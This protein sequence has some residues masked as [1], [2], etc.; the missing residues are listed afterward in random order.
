MILFCFKYVFNTGG[1]GDCGQPI[2]E[3][4]VPDARGSI[5]GDFVDCL[6]SVSRASRSQLDETEFSKVMTTTKQTVFIQLGI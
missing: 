3:V 4:R 1:K 6:R 5:L 2:M